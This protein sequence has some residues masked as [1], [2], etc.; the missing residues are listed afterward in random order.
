[1]LLVG[2]TFDR[3]WV[4]AHVNH[5]E[6]DVEVLREVP[7]L[8]LRVPGG[9]ALPEPALPPSQ[10]RCV[11]VVDLGETDRLDDAHLPGALADV[12]AAVG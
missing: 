12:L 7:Y 1:M 8:Q 4:L 10:R 9:E 2:A 5:E 11:A 6:L 3:A